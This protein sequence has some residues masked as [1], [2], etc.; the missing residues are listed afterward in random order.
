M[1]EGNATPHHNKP[2]LIQRFEAMLGSG[3]LYYFESQDYEEIIEYYFEQNDPPKAMKA[4]DLGLKQFPFSQ[5]FNIKKAQLLSLQNRTQEALNLIGKVEM[6]EGHSHE[7]LLTKGGIYSQMGLSDQAIQCYKEAAKISSDD[8]AEVF[9]YIAYEFESL[10]SYADAIF[11]LKKSLTREP[12][13]DTA[14][15]EI[16]YCFDTSERSEDAVK[17]FIAFTDE[18]PYSQVAWFCLGVSYARLGLFEKAIDAYEYAIAIDENFSSAYFNKA[19]SLANLSHYDDAIRVYKEVLERENPEVLT[20]YY[21]GECY[22]K[23]EDYQQA[24]IHY[25]KATTLDPDLPDAWMGMGVVLDQLGRLQEGIH[26]MKKAIHLSPQV[27]DYWHIFGEVQMRLGFQE[28][29]EGAFKKV[30]DLDPENTEVWMDYADLMFEQKM[31]E[32]AIGILSEGIK[33]HPDNAELQY[34][35]AACLMNL[36]ERQEGMKFLQNGLS[37]DYDKHAELFE[38]FPQLRENSAVLE[39]IESHRK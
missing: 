4:I 22:E 3:V 16:S 10:G 8:I 11:Y 17:Y 36:G 28:E 26:Y 37:L 14:L 7:L 34:R 25:K 35:M 12:S 39:V 19:N 13:S 6:M 1:K 20:Y 9:L 24:L 27:G 32:D 5:A 15:Y 38:Y 30:I 31:D 2:E 23:K 21:L 33:H 29:A 18:H